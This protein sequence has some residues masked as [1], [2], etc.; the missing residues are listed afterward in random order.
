MPTISTFLGIVI[1][2][3]WREHGPPHF[4]ARYGE[5]EAIIGIPALQLLR[6]H[7][8]PRALALVLEWAAAHR[9]ELM[10]D[11]QLCRANQVPKPIEPLE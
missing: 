10:H 1:T 2:M 7:L 8:P 9:E 5:H 6:G 3:Y 4:H 11:W